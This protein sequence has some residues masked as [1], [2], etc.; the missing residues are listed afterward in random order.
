MMT[1]REHIGCLVEQAELFG[2]RLGGAVLEG[3]RRPLL[4]STG[5]GQFS[6]PLFQI[7]SQLAQ[8]G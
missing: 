5:I 4:C 8:N 3:C 1:M 2:N 7:A 6:I